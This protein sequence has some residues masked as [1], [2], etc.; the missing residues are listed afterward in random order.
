MKPRDRN[1]S[2]DSRATMLMPAECAA[3]GVERA[4]GSARI[5][6]AFPTATGTLAKPEPPA[7]GS[8]G[9][10]SPRLR[11]GAATEFHP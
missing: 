10:S 7:S 11:H 4:A 1:N 9:S 2:D 5:R 3:V 8:P 6:A